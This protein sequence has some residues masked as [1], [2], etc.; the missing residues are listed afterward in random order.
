LSIIHCFVGRIVLKLTVDG[1]PVDIFL[2]LPI[3]AEH[4][5]AVIS[6]E[7]NHLQSIKAMLHEDE[8]C[9][10]VEDMWHIELLRHYSHTR[11]SMF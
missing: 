6:K 11:H 8:I 3:R 2:S 1:L 10:I 4:D 7:E 9:D 5:T